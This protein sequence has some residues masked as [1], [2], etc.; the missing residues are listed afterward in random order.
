M[1]NETDYRIYYVKMPGDVRG[2]V[3]IDKDGFA[4]IYIN[5]QL[6]RKARR[7]VLQ[8]ELRHISR[9]DHTNGGKITEVEV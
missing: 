6:S 1:Q 3:R 5:D 2:G 4:S 9:H 7:A 8:H